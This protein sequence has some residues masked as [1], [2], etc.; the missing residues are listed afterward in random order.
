MLE[1]FQEKAPK[2]TTGLKGTT[3]VDR[4]K[5]AGLSTLE[6]RRRIQVLS[7]VFKTLKGLDK[8]DSDQIFARRN[9]NQQPDSE[10]PP[11]I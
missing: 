3:D 1:K 5:E 9:V 4:S 11:G 10:P 8:A 2:M 7:Q 6:D